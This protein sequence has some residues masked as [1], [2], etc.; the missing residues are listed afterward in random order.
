MANSPKGFNFLDGLDT[1]KAEPRAKG[2][3]SPKPMVAKLVKAPKENPFKHAD[4]FRRP[5]RNAALRERRLKVLNT[6]LFHAIVNREI[7][8]MYGNAPESAPIT[9]AP[10]FGPGKALGKLLNAATG[11]KSLAGFEQYQALGSQW[12]RVVDMGCQKDSNP[13]AIGRYQSPEVVTVTR[14]AE[15]TASGEQFRLAAQYRNQN[16]NPLS[17]MSLS[18]DK[19]TA[20]KYRAHKRALR[21]VVTSMTQ[22]MRVTD[23]VGLEMANERS[24]N[25]YRRYFR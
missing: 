4:L 17:D 18:R 10:S 20:R 14:R 23:N 8:A 22:D 13:R 1:V 6:D 7:E 2:E 25:D 16:G 12:K 15:V 3:K 5:D 21:K 24:A 11:D 19:M 9:L